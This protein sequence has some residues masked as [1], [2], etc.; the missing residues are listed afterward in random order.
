VRSSPIETLVSFGTGNGIA[1]QIGTE[2]VITQWDIRVVLGSEEL[3]SGC[4]LYCRVGGGGGGMGKL[5]RAP[6]FTRQVFRR[7]GM[8]RDFGKVVG[9]RQTV[10]YIQ[11]ALS[12]L[13]PSPFSCANV[14]ASSEQLSTPEIPRPWMGVEKQGSLTQKKK[15]TDSSKVFSKYILAIGTQ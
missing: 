5:E 13:L 8:I 2:E 15:K 1:K 14:L 10:S 11:C 4:Q 6:K 3:C 12:C 9:V 7:E